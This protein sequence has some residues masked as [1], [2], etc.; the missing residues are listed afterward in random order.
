MESLS[1][2]F[3]L[4]RVQYPDDTSDGVSKFM[5]SRDLHLDMYL[6]YLAAF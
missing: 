5:L 1:L 6:D 2:E 4:V 3:I